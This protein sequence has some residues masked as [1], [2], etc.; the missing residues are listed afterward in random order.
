MKKSIFL[1]LAT[2]L[3]ATNAWAWCGNS[4]ITVNGL[5][6]T[7]SN[8]YVHEGGKFDGK[9]LGELTVLNL[10][11]EL[12]VWP[13]SEEAAT[14]YYSIDN[15]EAVAISLPKTGTEGG[16]SK[17]SGSATV[18][19]SA[20]A[21]GEHTL[22]VW[23]NHGSDWDS[24][25]S[26]NFVATFTTLESIVYKDVTYTI[27]CA[28]FKGAPEITWWGANGLENSIEPQKMDSLGYNK[29]AY[30]FAQID[31]ITGVN[32]YI[33]LAGFQSKT[34][35]IHESN[36]LTYFYTILQDVVVKGDFDEWGEGVLLETRSDDYK[37]ISGVV[38][39]NAE[40][41]HEFKLI[42]N[43]NWKGVNDDTPIITKDAPTTTIGTGD[44]NAKIKSELKGGYTFTYNYLTQE[45]TVAYP[46]AGTLDLGEL[47]PYY[48]FDGVQLA[49][50]NYNEITIYNLQDEAYQ[51]G[52]EFEAEASIKHNGE[53]LT[54]TGKASWTLAD[55]VMTLVATNMVDENNTV[56][57]TITATALAPQ[58][59]TIVCNGDYKVDDYG[60]ASALIFTATTEDEEFV[61]I[62]ITEYPKDEE[63]NQEPAFVEGEIDGVFFDVINSYNVTDGE[64][65][66]KTLNV[67]AMDGAGNTYTIT[68]TATPRVTPSINIYDAA[69]VEINGDGELVFNVTYEGQAMI[70]TCWE[71]YM[72]PG[73]YG[74]ILSG[75]E[76]EYSC[77]SGAA[78]VQEDS[79]Y[80][81]TGLM[82]DWDE[83][84]YNVMITTKANTATAL[85]N[86]TSTVAP[87]KVIENNQLIIIKNG[88]R[89][90]VMGATIK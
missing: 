81:I 64:G 24:N 32:F 54:L 18:D 40:Q 52:E 29:W 44:L 69:F 20:L 46:Y 15:A 9:D 58:E 73:T 4:F 6:C 87:V 12:Q 71:S 49:D 82:T 70:C 74:V 36:K 48:G 67:V 25:D 23:F 53:W 37:T 33:E 55:G 66:V 90:N 28:G 39:L 89:Y 41:T 2:I 17:H 27:Q 3:C 10:G 60:F 31:S 88:V 68:I 76:N 57:Y 14:M 19:L 62:S 7:G 50:D 80:T 45:V 63:G 85:D 8:S 83:Q 34:I 75:E 30:T 13:S 77:F 79:H 21:A 65:D 26:K 47:A 84:E 42:V 38:Q 59:R 56:N 86:V 1:I 35:K 72:E 11:G 51:Y 61:K 5:W 78:L 16:N 22:A 43:D